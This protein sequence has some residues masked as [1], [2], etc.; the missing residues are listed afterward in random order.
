MYGGC[1]KCCGCRTC[2]QRVTD[3]VSGVVR[4]Q[5]DTDDEEDDR[6]FDVI[7]GDQQ[8]D[9]FDEFGGKIEE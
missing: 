6:S 9:V 1:C 4:F 2:L 3:F 7:R 5:A 8:S